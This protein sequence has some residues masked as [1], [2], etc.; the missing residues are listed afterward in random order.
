MSFFRCGK[1]TD[2]VDQKT[3]EQHLLHSFYPEKPE[4]NMTSLNKE[5]QM[6][7]RKITTKIHKTPVSTLQKDTETQPILK[8]AIRVARKKITKHMKVKTPSE[9]AQSIG[10]ESSYETGFA[11]EVPSETLAKSK[12]RSKITTHMRHKPY[13]ST[14]K[15]RQENSPETGFASVPKDEPTI[16]DILNDPFVYREWIDSIKKSGGSTRRKKI[17]GRKTRRY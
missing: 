1:I 11:S 6:C 3:I 10:R 15:I 9:I 12:P 17:R 14:T 16:D 4:V 5:Q 7:L 13:S 2:V 8:M